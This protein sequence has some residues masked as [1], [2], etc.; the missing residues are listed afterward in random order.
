MV[1]CKEFNE[2]YYFVGLWVNKVDF[3]FFVESSGKMGIVNWKWIVLFMKFVVDVFD[4]LK[5][6]MRIGMVVEGWMFYVVVD[7]N[8]MVKKLLLLVV[9]GLILLFFGD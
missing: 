8:R 6:G 5:I 9:M 2:I 3:V 4:I 1:Y 7:F